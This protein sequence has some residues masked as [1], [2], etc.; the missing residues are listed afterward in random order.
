M[1]RN[2]KILIWFDKEILLGGGIIK[3]LKQLL[4]KFYKIRIN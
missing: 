2:F 3:I 4:V 1:Q